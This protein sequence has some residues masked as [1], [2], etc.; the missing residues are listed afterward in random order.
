MAEMHDPEDFV[1]SIVSLGLI[2]IIIYTL[3]GSLIYA[4]VG[5]NVSSPALLSA[6]KLVARVAFGFAL[7]VIFISPAACVPRSPDAIS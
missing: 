4:F 1:K 6:G 7:P 5:A 3:T 2:E